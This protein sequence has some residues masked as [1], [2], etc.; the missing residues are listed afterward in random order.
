MAAE[1]VRILR[2]I[3]ALTMNDLQMWGGCEAISIRRPEYFAPVR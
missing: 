2:F 1:V 3:I